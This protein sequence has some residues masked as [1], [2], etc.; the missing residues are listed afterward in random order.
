MSAVRGLYNMQTAG[1]SVLGEHGHAEQHAANRMAEEVRYTIPTERPGYRK[2][3]AALQGNEENDVPTWV[4]ASATGRV[5]LAVPTREKQYLIN[6]QEIRDAQPREQRGSGVVRTDPITDVEV[7][8]FQRQK[9]LAEYAKR[10]QYIDMFYNKQKPGETLEVLKNAPDHVQTRLAQIKSEFEFALRKRL[11]DEWGVNSPEDL[12]FRYL[13]DQGY[14]TG[15]EL[16]W[17]AKY[18]DEYQH[19]IFSPYAMFKQR[20][21]D[22]SGFGVPYSGSAYGQH[23]GGEKPDWRIAQ[24][25]PGG[26]G[27]DEAMAKAIYKRPEFGQ[28]R[29]ALGALNMNTD[30][31]LMNSGQRTA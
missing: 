24:T 20:D 19:G 1:P 2:E 29:M 25:G 17:E 6:K 3:L 30:A 26:L 21:S 9:D 23:P 7:G 27:S 14:I 15:P 16:K 13:L 5:K 10:D 12:E 8:Y 31:R 18:G 4:N 11:V 22:G 28:P